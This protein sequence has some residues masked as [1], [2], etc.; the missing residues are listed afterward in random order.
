MADLL[1]QVGDRIRG[2]RKAAGFTQAMLAAQAELHTTYLS[3]IENG[4]AENLT[5]STLHDIGVVLKVPVRELVDAESDL[6]SED[7]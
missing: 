5:L 1:K 4:K 3:Q 6:T 2:Y 7:E